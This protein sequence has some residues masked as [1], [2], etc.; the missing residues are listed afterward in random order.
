MYKPQDFNC[1]PRMLSTEM[2]ISSY[3]FAVYYFISKSFP[4]EYSIITKRAI[5]Q[6]KAGNACTCARAHTHTRATLRTSRAS[7][8]IALRI[9]TAM[10]RYEVMGI[11]T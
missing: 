5:H 7:M 11:Y 8:P 1:L 10:H 4:L 2:T 6:V 9:L 3:I